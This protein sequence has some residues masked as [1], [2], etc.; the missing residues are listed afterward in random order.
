MADLGQIA[1][2]GH[3]IDA[4]GILRREF[5]QC[6]SGLALHDQIEEVE[7]AA[8]IRQ[9]QHRADLIGRGLARAMADRLIQQRLRIAR[10]PFGGTG[11]QGEGLVRDLGPFGIGDLAQQGNLGFRF[12]PAQVEALTA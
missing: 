11:D 2:D 7:N 3:R 6:G 5:G 10:R 12:D 9:P 1:Q 4:I 8:T